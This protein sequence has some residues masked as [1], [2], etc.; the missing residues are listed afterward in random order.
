MVAQAGMSLA[1]SGCFATRGEK[2]ILRLAQD[3]MSFWAKR[4]ICSWFGLCRAV[5]L[6]HGTLL[7]CEDLFLNL[8]S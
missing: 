2:Q 7:F 3:D 6:I 8:E 4:R 5:A 1:S